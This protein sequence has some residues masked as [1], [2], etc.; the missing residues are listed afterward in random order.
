MSIAR[1]ARCSAARSRSRHG[2]A[3]LPDETI[4]IRSERV[5]PDRAW[6]RFLAKGV[7][8][9]LEGDANDY[10]GKGLSG[11]RLVIYPP[12]ERDLQPKKIS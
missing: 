12:R 2:S 4:R 11:G 8:L 1:L 5:R 6:A 10:V 7:T 3:G 9:T